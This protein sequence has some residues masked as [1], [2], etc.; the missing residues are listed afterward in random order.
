M[1]TT[2]YSIKK[3][4]K[5]LTFSSVIVTLFSACQKLN[6]EQDITL[7]TFTVQADYTE[8]NAEDT[9]TALVDGTNPY[10]KWLASDK[11]NVWEAV[12]DKN[13]ACFS[14]LK[15]NLSD[16]DKSATFD[17]QLSGTDPKGTKYCYTSIYPEGAVTASGGI[18]SFEIPATQTLL[19]GNFAANADILIGK[20]VIIDS[21]ISNGTGISVR[22]KRPGTAVKLTLKGI[23]VGE[24]INVI[25]ISAPS[26]KKIAGRCKV[27]LLTGDITDKA[28]QS[29]INE[30]TLK[31]NGNIASGEDVFY[32]RCLDGTWEKG[33]SVSIRVETDFAI[34]T[35]TVNLP[36]DYV[37]VDGGLTK[38]GFQGFTKTKFDTLPGVF[39]VGNNVRVRFSKGNLIAS[40]DAS[41]KPT[42]WKFATNQYDFLGGGGANLTVG[43]QG[44][45]FDLFSWSN[46]STTSNWGINKRTDD[47]VSSNV[48][49]EWGQNI[50]GSWRTLTEDEWKYLVGGTL[51][52]NKR[53][54]AEEKYGWATVCEK[55][56]FI[57]LPDQFTDPC[58]NQ[59]DESL[60]DAFKS[61][62]KYKDNI[63]KDASNWD[64]MERA[65]AVFLP[66]CGCIVEEDSKFKYLDGEQTNTRYWSSTPNSNYQAFVLD[67]FTNSEQLSIGYNS[68]PSKYGAPVRLVTIITNTNDD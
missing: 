37:F 10:V 68:I 28:Y 3:S 48:F 20:P 12:D 62:G 66:A 56:G 35:K 21:R 34:Y 39:S 33:S 30:I 8:P 25:K 46:T 67:L 26:G 36:Q 11:I 9:K 16:N 14:T 29:G 5:I 50:S 49:K 19:N 2:S 47:C 61:R 65:G 55:H 54:D 44:G 57:L 24:K 7:G 63:Y 38:F 17:I 41:A 15:T 58:T 22:F 31:C 4:L 52:D 64:A 27:N 32:F 53:P 18:Y 13:N 23:S 43:T 59:S 51:I 42:S 60:S 45:D 40:I 1:K 6:V